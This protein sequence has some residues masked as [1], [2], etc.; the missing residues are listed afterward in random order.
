MAGDCFGDAVNVAAR[1]LDHAGDN[2]TLVTASVL[3]GLTREQHARFPQP[4]PDAAARPRRAGACA[5]ARRPAPRRRRRGHR[6]S[7]TSRR[8]A[9]PEGIRLIWLDLNRVYASQQ[10]P[11][12]LGRSPQ[13][14]LLRRRL[15]RVALACAHRLARRHLPAHRPQLQ[16]HLRAL[17]RRARVVSLRRGTCTLHGSGVIGLGGSPADASRP[18][19]RFEVLRF[20]DTKRQ[21]LT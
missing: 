20:A 2:E 12:V 6:S 10:L 16:R 14:H 5:P 17:R 8:R 1:L 18:C 19:V 9:E 21:P 4:R 11:V 13:A 3:A 15:A 7:A